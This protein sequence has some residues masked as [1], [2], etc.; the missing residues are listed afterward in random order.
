MTKLLLI[1]DHPIFR[2][3]LA[4]LI[5]MT[6]GF[7]VVGEASN[8]AE[9]LDQAA[10][11]KPDVVLLDLTLGNESGLELLKDL[12][13]LHTD[14]RVLVLSMHDESVYA[15]RALAAGAHGYVQKQEASLRVMEALRTVVQGKKWFSPEMKDKLLENLFDG[16]RESLGLAR[17]SDRELEVFTWM[18]RGLGTSKIAETLGVSVKTIDTHKEHL[19]QKLH[20][21]DSQELRIKAA[22]WM[23][24]R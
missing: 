16:R 22:Q 15:E 10:A 17:L 3:G 8:R 14:L 13:A 24:D 9:A 6:P 18:A 11:L 20:C 1:D 21:R 4:S 19:K 2:K 7:L 23:A 12:R 5:A